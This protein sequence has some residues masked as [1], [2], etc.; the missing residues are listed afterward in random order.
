M[1]VERAPPLQPLSSSGEQCSRSWR[2]GLRRGP[3][4]PSH[5]DTDPVLSFLSCLLRHARWV[6]NGISGSKLTFFP[7][8]CPFEAWPLILIILAIACSSSNLNLNSCNFSPTDLGEHSLSPEKLPILSW[9]LSSPSARER[10]YSP[11]HVARL[12]T[13]QCG[14]LEAA[15][16]THFHQWQPQTPSQLGTKW[17]AFRGHQEQVELR[18]QYEH[19]WGDYSWFIFPPRRPKPFEK[20][21]AMPEVSIGR[22]GHFVRLLLDVPY[23]QSCECFRNF[24]SKHIWT[25]F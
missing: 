22:K 18:E 17:V 4:V 14:V 1:H 19:W 15:Y 7:T 12:D 25:S 5:A 2:P 24:F 16:L 20:T 3:R 6:A 11:H 13:E 21:F 9:V 23:T 10:P 8:L